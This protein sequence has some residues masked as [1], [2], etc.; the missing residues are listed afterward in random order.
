[1]EWKKLRAMYENTPIYRNEAD[2][3]RF[4]APDDG[5]LY[6]IGSTHFNPFT[7]EKIYLIKVGRSDVSLSRRMRDYRTENP[8]M[9][10]IAFNALPKQ[11]IR[12]NERTC[13]A[14]LYSICEGLMENSEEWVKVS[15]ETYLEICEKGFQYFAER[16]S[17]INP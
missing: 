4:S 10:H 6:L 2:P 14:I 7:E 8:M 17:Q 9:F 16:I 13:H 12:E 11:V 15:G 1:M 3:L 5:G